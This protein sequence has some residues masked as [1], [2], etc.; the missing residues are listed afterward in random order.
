[1]KS[2]EKGNSTAFDVS[3]VVNSIRGALRVVKREQKSS[4]LPRNALASIIDG[5]DSFHSRLRNAAGSTHEHR[6]KKICCDN[7]H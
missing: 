5:A 3:Y 6:H 7:I 1:M 2:G 4:D